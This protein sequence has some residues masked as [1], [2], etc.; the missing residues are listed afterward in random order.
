MK[1]SIGILRSVLQIFLRNGLYLPT[2]KV[3]TYIDPTQKIMSIR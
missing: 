3:G 2:L 1:L